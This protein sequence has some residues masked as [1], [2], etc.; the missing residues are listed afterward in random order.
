MWA[1]GR[2]IG[3]ASQAADVA[4]SQGCGVERQHKG[5]R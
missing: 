3:E 1:A 4:T 2:H 5:R